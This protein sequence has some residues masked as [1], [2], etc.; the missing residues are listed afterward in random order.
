[1]NSLR[2]LFVSERFWPIV[3]PAAMAIEQVSHAL[4]RRGHVVRVLTRRWQKYWPPEL[5]VGDIDVVRLP[6]SPRTRFGA[7]RLSKNVAQWLDLHRVHFDLILIDPRDTLLAAVIAWVTR[8]R[9]PICFW[10]TCAEPMTEDEA[11]RFTRPRSTSAQDHAAWIGPLVEPVAEVARSLVNPKRVSTLGPFVDC[12]P[13]DDV[14]RTKA[15][16]ALADNHP[17]HSLGKDDPLIV[18]VGTWNDARPILPWIDSWDVVCRTYPGA[19]LWIVGDGDEVPRIADHIR[20]R[21]MAHQILLVGRFDDW[22]DLFKAADL[23]VQADASV[24]PP[25]PSL[26][27]MN[28]ELPIVARGDNRE[29]NAWLNPGVNGFWCRSREPRAMAKAIV[30]ALQQPEQRASIARAAQ[31]QVRRDHNLDAG[32]AELE[33][34]GHELVAKLEKVRS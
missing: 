17:L 6:Y 14:S 13:L 19:R 20:S 10:P 2:V 24:V 27:A 23:F 16:A 1:M 11:N 8:N 34:L 32:V 26:C 12:L 30:D 15:R 4:A 18:S 22:S 29:Q 3:D 31:L 5:R 9:F 25:F 33:R 21:Q 28:A 7:M